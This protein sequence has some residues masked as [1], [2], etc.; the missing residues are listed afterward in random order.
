[1]PPKRKRPHGGASAVE[2]PA[3]VGHGDVNQGYHAWLNE[4]INVVLNKWPD[5]A[6]WEPL[7]DS[8]P[9]EEGLRGFMSPYN[10]VAYTAMYEMNNVN[11]TYHCGINFMWQDLCSSAIPFVPLYQTRVEEMA[12]QLT[13]TQLKHDI[14]LCASFPRDLPRGACFRVSPDEYPHAVIVKVSTAIRADAS[15]NE[16]L[17]WKRVLLSTP[18]TFKRLDSSDLRYAEAN[19]LR[20]DFANKARLVVHTARQLVYNI[21]GFKARKG[22]DMSA[23]AIAAFWK[24][25]IRVALTDTA[26]GAVPDMHKVATIDACLTVNSRLLCITSCEDIIKASESSKG[27]LSAWN[28]LWKLDELIKRGGTPARIT[29]IMETVD[30]WIA[31][32]KITDKDV[33]HS[34]LKTGKNSLSD[35][36]LQQLLLRKHLLGPFLDSLNLEGFV[37]DKVRTI[38]ASHAKYRELYHPLTDVAD[39]TFI[40]EYPKAA[41]SLM[42]FLEGIL[43]NTTAQEDYLLRQAAK[44]Y[45]TETEVLSWKPWCES[46]AAIRQELLGC[47]TAQVAQPEQP[48]E[49]RPATQ[50]PGAETSMPDSELEPAI[51]E[52]ASRLMQQ[53]VV[54]VL[55]PLSMTALADL[56]KASPLGTV[57]STDGSNVLILAD[58]NS[59]G[60]PD[61]QPHIR[62]CPINNNTLRMWL[63]SVLI[64]RCGSETPDHLQSG[65]IFCCITG[66]KDRKAAWCKPLMFGAGKDKNRSFARHITMFVTEES[67]RSG[68]QK[69]QG[70][71]KLTQQVHM[72]GAVNTFS[73]VAHARF[74]VHGG[75]TKSDVFGPVQLP[76]PEDLPR[77]PAEERLMYL[78]KRRVLAGGK[79]DEDDEPLD[80]GDEDDVEEAGQDVS[81]LMHHLLPITVIT[82][83]VTAYNV[84]HV[85]DFCPTPMPLMIALLE[86]GCSYF[87]M[88]ANEY[89]REYLSKQL[90]TDIIAALMNPKSPLSEG[91]FASLAKAAR[92]CSPSQNDEDTEEEE[93]DINEEGLEVGNDEDDKAGGDNSNMEDKKDTK[94]PPNVKT[95]AKGKT[96]AKAKGSAA[97]GS[98]SGGGV[99]LAKLLAEARASASAQK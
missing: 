70:H 52:A 67:W 23:A 62:T 84:R 56:I 55:E 81:I 14:I 35:V 31:I 64:A 97:T 33:T 46:I 65:D 7:S 99:D 29:H 61:V 8:L 54:L 11:E 13:P 68:R 73:N 86:K 28:S 42:R 44:N 32:G 66:G 71:A 25:S 72:V 74:P 24:E 48:E 76:R 17:Q 95:K 26:G 87:G 10:Q 59:Y 34:S 40:F 96:K 80:P 57:R 45:N 21:A 51:D 49:T 4:H 93:H 43:Y 82:D 9:N 79:A 89:Q 77:L 94:P 88:V 1:M 63:R 5:I 90:K 78:G 30:D 12:S 92:P 60:T 91:R 41:Q 85:I 53:R 38:F 37:K 83:L 39:T 16:L 19:S 22:P 58:L 36:A 47:S 20:A 2:E 69:F 15:E 75:S 27:P 3:A 50:V 98:G 18:C 6:S